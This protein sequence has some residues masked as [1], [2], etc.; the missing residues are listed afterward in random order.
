MCMKA[1]D[2][3]IGVDVQQ[4]LALSPQLFFV[5]KDKGTTKEIQGEEPYTTQLQ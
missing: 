3:N 2:F 1:Q 4:V 5:E